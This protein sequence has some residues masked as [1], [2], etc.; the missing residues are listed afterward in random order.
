MARQPES[1]T[2]TQGEPTTRMGCD[3]LNIMGLGLKL[4]GDKENR[5]A[6]ESR[7]VDSWVDSASAFL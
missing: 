2:S 4:P 3:I 1:S 6:Q 5:M 7:D